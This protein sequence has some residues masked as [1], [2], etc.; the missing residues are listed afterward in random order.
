MLAPT[1]D[2]L[3]V[4]Y[5]SEDAAFAQWPTLRLTAAGYKVWCDQIKLLGGESYPVDIDAAIWTRKFRCSSSS[6]TSLAT[7]TCRGCETRL[8][9]PAPCARG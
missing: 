4:S 5:A 8:S 1:R 3:F 2:H 7:S 6:M 9:W